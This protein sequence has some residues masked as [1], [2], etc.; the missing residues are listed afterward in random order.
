M[1]EQP[2]LTVSSIIALLSPKHLIEM[3]KLLKAKN[4][5]V[6][7]EGYKSTDDRLKE[8]ESKYFDLVWLARKSQEDYQNPAIKEPWDKVVAKYPI[9]TGEIADPV[10][11]D[12]THGFNSGMLACVRL[13]RPYLLDVDWREEWHSD[14]DDDG[15]VLTRDSL[16]EEAE[17]EFPLL[18]T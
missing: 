1:A 7:P 17:A 10:T 8:L 11:G 9:E 5:D 16:V 4:Y 6:Y 2:S 13:L 3:Y 15:W 12:W 14:G 18:D